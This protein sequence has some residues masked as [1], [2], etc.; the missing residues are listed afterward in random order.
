MV[1]LFSVID[2]KRP[3]EQG[4]PQ[5]RSASEPIARRTQDRNVSRVV[6]NTQ[7]LTECRCLGDG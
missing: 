2:V 7:N 1:D 5:E 3:E 4:V 6:G